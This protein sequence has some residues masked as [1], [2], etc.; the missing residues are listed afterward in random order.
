M[1]K[2]IKHSNK[3]IIVCDFCRTIFKCSFDEIKEENFR[4]GKRSFI[5]RYVK[6]PTCKNKLILKTIHDYDDTVKAEIL[7]H[8]FLIGKK[9]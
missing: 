5:R 6:C 1:K 4:G 8:T 2:I 3:N 9:I 7:C